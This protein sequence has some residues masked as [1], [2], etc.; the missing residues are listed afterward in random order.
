MRA[1]ELLTSEVIDRNGRPL[2]RVRDIRVRRDGFRVVGLVIGEGP[3]VGIAH[4][5]GF[6]EGRAQGPWLL[7]ALTRRATRNTRFVPAESVVD[8]GAGV[9][10][11]SAD[12][13]DLRPLSAELRAE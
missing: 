6:T 11:I 12:A 2:G 3:F 7:R 13:G 9:V 5:W 8:W 10:A 4:A 1:S